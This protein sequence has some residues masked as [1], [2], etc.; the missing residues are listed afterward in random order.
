MR[1]SLTSRGSRSGGR[2]TLGDGTTQLK[3]DE[4]RQHR[5]VHRLAV[6]QALALNADFAQEVGEELPAG[7]RP[8]HLHG[9]IFLH[10]VEEVLKRGL[11]PE[12]HLLLVRD[13]PVPCRQRGVGLPVYRG[14]V[15]RQ[16]LGGQLEGARLRRHRHA[17]VAVPQRDRH[18]AGEGRHDIDRRR[19]VRPR[20]RHRRVHPANA[21]LV[22]QLR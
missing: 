20:G 2:A 6:E 21:V 1:R 7:P 14:P 22:N 10:V 19:S 3:L 18:V 11:D 5:V 15:V 17:K 8:P 13:D 16:H 9:G 4:P 12:V